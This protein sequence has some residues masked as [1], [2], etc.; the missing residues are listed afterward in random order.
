MPQPIARIPV[1][2]ALGGSLSP[3]VKVRGG[4]LSIIEMP[5]AWDA[6]N[7]TFQTSGDGSTFMNLYD[8]NGT[9]VTVTADASRRVRLEPS[10]WASIAE[11]KVRSGTSGA[12]VAQSADRTL[13]L[14][15]WE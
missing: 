4:L 14:E 6:A 5:A 12:A 13:Y 11:I 10:Q 3:A 1:T 9:E 7:L 15:I 8:E 2:I